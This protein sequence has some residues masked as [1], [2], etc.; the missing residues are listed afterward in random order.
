MKI[1]FVGIGFAHFRTKLRYGTYTEFV[2]LT[3]PKVTSRS[4]GV[5]RLPCKAVIGLLAS[6]AVNHG[7]AFNFLVAKKPA[8]SA[9]SST[10][11]SRVGIRARQLPARPVV[12]SELQAAHFV[13]SF[14]W[15][16]IRAKHVTSAVVRH[17]TADAT[18]PAP[19]STSTKPVKQKASTLKVGFYLLVWY[20]LTI[21][22][23][24]YNKAT[25]NRLN[26]PWILSTLQ[27]A[28]GAV[29]V[30]TIW[31]LGIRKSPKLN[32]D[33]IKSVAPLAALHTISHIAAVV[34]LSAG[35]IGFVQIVKVR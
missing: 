18:S 2:V 11:A 19:D 17:S 29:Y 35:A 28:I 22:Y 6:A 33:N 8:M 12:K 13:P 5:M 30:S 15:A 26:I 14:E 4:P 10:F 27:L 24:I 1:H 7:V 23:N 3:D 25:L 32:I 9:A 21:G 34:G 31:A 20:S 16:C